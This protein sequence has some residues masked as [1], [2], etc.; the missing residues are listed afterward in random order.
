MSY[1]DWM[2]LAAAIFA[3]LSGASAVVAYL[4]QRRTQATS[5]E[6]QVN[7]LIEKM[8]KA[9][10]DLDASRTITAEKFAANN[11]ALA[12]LRG[13]ALEA[14]K[15]I[16]RARIKPDWFQNMVLAYAFSQTGDLKSADPYWQGAVTA[17]LASNNHPAHVSSLAARA[18]FY[19]NRHLDNDWELARE[20]FNAAKNE[21]D[22]DPDRQ[23]PDLT[24]QQV[25]VLLLQQ[26][27]FELDAEGQSTAVPLIVAAF[28][29]ANTIGAQWR[30][31]TVL[32]NL[33]DLVAGTQQKA[34]FP[35]LLQQVAA[36]LSQRD[37]DIAAMLPA[38]F[39]PVPADG[40]LF[41]GLPAEH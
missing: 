31:R 7:D 3:G 22:N 13:L 34:G 24:A 6:N 32:K 12:R 27:A 18:E 29:K 28:M 25:A 4:L 39:A 35:D 17:A 9:L 33:G 41:A 10:A 8:Q 16:T 37:P 5:D 36:E 20:D 40:T 2:A 11:V 38:A 23:G 21:L 30:R 26:A 15:V 19:Y 1:A 14:R